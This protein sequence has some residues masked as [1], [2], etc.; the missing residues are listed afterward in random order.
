[1]GKKLNLFISA[2]LVCKKNQDGLGAEMM[3]GA[4]LD[5]LP[6]LFYIQVPLSKGLIKSG[7]VKKASI[8]QK[9]LLKFNEKP[10]P[11]G[12]YSKKIQ[13]KSTHQKSMAS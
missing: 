3:W 13:L 4:I 9:G 6:P 1:V 2:N 7:Y 12:I 10:G 11:F 8:S 5:G